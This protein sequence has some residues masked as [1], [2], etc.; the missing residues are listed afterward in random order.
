MWRSV[1][2]IA[3]RLT[4]I[5]T[6]LAPASGSGTSSSHRPRARSFFTSAF[7]K[8]SRRRGAPLRSC[9]NSWRRPLVQNL[10][11]EKPQDLRLLVEWRD[12]LGRRAAGSGGGGG[13]AAPAEVARSG[14]RRVGGRG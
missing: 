3:V 14:E 12:E 5:F 2:Q 6:S 13:G 8:S 7:I 9:D 1:P 10:R 11:V 4:R